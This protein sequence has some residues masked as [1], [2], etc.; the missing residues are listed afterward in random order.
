MP[1]WDKKN[2]KLLTVEM[3]WGETKYPQAE[4]K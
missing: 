3:S 4:G 2:A 1:F